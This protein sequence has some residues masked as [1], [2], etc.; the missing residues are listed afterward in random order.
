MRTSLGFA[1][2]GLLTFAACSTPSHGANGTIDFVP[3]D[4][5]NAGCNFDDR[6]AVNATT[7]VY[8]DGVDNFSTQGL[9]LDTADSSIAAI[10]SGDDQRVTLLGVSPGPVDLLAVDDSGEVVDWT[11]INVA[12]P[13]DLQ[14]DVTGSVDGP[15][16]TTTSNEDLYFTTR[17]TS[18]DLYTNPMA[19]GSQLMGKLRYD[20]VI[21]SATAAAIDTG[22][23]IPSGRFHMTAPVGEHDISL[24]SG[25]VLRDVHFSVN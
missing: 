21:D 17:G 18:I 5:G 1:S 23:D 7:D 13:D 6:L 16:A 2:L 19:D 3:T 15:H 9:H 12:A 8:M 22:A 11:T 4:C 25:G 14:V 10:T 24:A 20:V